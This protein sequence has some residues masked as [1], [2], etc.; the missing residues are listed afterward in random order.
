M[1]IKGIVS[2]AFLIPLALSAQQTWTYRQ[3]V[4]YAREKNISLQQ[5]RLSAE[6]SKI[7]LEAAEAQWQPTLSFATTQAYTNTPW[8]EGKDKNSYASNYGLNAGWSIWNGG[9]RTATINQRKVQVKASEASVDGLETDLEQNILQVYV[10]LLYSREAIEIC[11]EAV[12]LSAAQEKR[13]VQL[14]QAGKMSKVDYAQIAAQAEQ[15]N[16]SLVNAQGNYASQCTE[17]K[18]LLELGIDSDVEPQ[19]VDWSRDEIIAALPPIAESYNLALSIDNQLKAAVLQA[20]AAKM[21]ER[22]AKS[23]GLPQISL[24]AGIGTGY[25]AP[26]TAFVTQLKRGVNENI[27]VTVTVPILDRK[28]TKTA[29]AQAKVSALDADLTREARETTIGRDIESLYTDVRSAQARYLAGEK[30]VEAATLSNDLVNERFELGYVNPVELLAAHN[31]LT[32]A[33][34]ELTQAKYM[35]MLGKK[36]IEI[37]RTNTTTL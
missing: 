21:Q 1:R 2:A 30:Q 31:A 37:Y 18:R 10:N 8:A 34:R 22:V 36:K 3:C 13:A 25:Y 6:S 33:K 7:N 26:G 28:Q 16:Y 17:L 11:K 14:M 19:Q 20:E 5:A 29:V 9:E 24:N 32:S 12:E 4:D 27:G 15:D 35:T 23:S